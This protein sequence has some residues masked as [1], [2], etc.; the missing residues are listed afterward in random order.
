MNN[1]CLISRKTY[2]VNDD[3]TI[4][5]PAIG[6]IK[7]GEGKDDE[8]LFWEE[9]S[10]FTKVPTDMISEL[11]DKMLSLNEAIQKCLEGE[12]DEEGLE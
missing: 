2:K 7:Y 10:L 9:V 1:C 12:K 4:N 5:I 8:Q 3:V 6:Q 11:D